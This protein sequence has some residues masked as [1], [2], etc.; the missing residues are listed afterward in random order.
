MRDRP[1]GL[2]YLPGA[3]ALPQW[4]AKPTAVLAKR[5]PGIDWRVAADSADFR[6]QLSEAAIAAVYV[7]KEKWLADAP[8][9]RL[10]STPAAGKDWIEVRSRP[11]LEVRFGSFHGENMAE[12]VAGLMLAFSRGIK[13]SLDHQA[14]DPWARE[15]VTATM[16][17]LR[18]STAL[19][20]GFG[21][22]GKWIGRVL[23]PFGLRLIGVNRTDLTRPEWL[24]AEDQVRNRDELDELLPQTDHLIVVLPGEASSEKVIDARRLALLPS[25]AFVYNVGRG[26][27]IDEAALADAL[28][29]GKVAGAGLDVFEQEPLPADAVIRTCPNTILMP[30]VSAFGPNYL[31]LYL[32][33]LVRIVE[34]LFPETV[35]K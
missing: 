32:R 5:F 6:R 31:D 20:L 23:K 3:N 13:T 14:A 8:K 11:G 24:D 30:H 34:G 21:H 29:S 19:I 16:R 27:A 26:N 35:E 25:T 10:V 28:K 22:I 33:E 18:G 17:P 7:F 15:T 9:L 12:T 1:I 2:I 4:E